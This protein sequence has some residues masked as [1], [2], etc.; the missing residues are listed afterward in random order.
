MPRRHGYS[1][2]GTRC[3]GTQDCRAGGRV[4]VMGALA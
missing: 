2:K 3:Y 1:K 4:N